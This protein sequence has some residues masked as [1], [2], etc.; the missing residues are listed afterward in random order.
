[1]TFLLYNAR[2][3]A[4]KSESSGAMAF[5]LSTF[6]TFFAAQGKPGVATSMKGYFWPNAVG[7]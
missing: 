4:A 2:F 1:M 7:H 3:R 6:A 5:A